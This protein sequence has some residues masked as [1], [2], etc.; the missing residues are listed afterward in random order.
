MSE[1]SYLSTTRVAYDLVSVDY[2][3]LLEGVL[4]QSPFDRAMLG[5]FAEQVQ[6]AG[7]VADIGCGPGL[8]A[9]H[10]AGLG[11][12][13]T[14]ID[15]SPGMI[16]EA[17]RRHPGLR[18]VVGAMA[19]L[20]LPDAG[21]AGVLAWY[22]IIHTPPALLPAVF[23]EFHRVLCPDGE[24]LLAF[25]VGDEPRHLSHAYGHDID[26]DAYRL[27]PEKITALL[28]EAGFSVYVTM[29]RQPIG[30]NEKSPQAYLMA[31][32]VGAGRAA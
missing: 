3:N 9:A 22:S 29:V 7:P 18:F 30:P 5:A 20:D 8:L 1:P 13:V 32:R 2:A 28:I 21:L 6:S 15:L 17:R 25:Q 4:E 24:L 19:A 26:L 27:S 31:R 14:G 10:L 23:A 12:D 16:S 11:L